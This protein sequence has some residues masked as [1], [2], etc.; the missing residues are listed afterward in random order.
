MATELVRT[1]Q[2]ILILDEM[3]RNHPEKYKEYLK[4]RRSKNEKQKSTRN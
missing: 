3:R 4:K 1:V 2:M